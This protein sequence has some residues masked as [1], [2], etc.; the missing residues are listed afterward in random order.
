MK[1]IGIVVF[2]YSPDAIAVG[3]RSDHGV[4]D[5]M[6]N[7]RCDLI[8]ALCGCLISDEFRNCL[9]FEMV[10]RDVVKAYDDT[11]RRYFDDSEIEISL[12]P[13]FTK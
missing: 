8:L 3:A 6:K 5:V 10:V 4:S 7:I 13:F 11:M 2:Q 9:F 12:H 1:I